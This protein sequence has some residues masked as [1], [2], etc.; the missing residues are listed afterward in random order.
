MDGPVSAET[1][2]A[3]DLVFH[4]AAN[5]DTDADGRRGARQ[6]RGHTEPPGVAASGVAGRQNRLHQ[7][8]GGPRPGCRS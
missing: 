1:P 5:I 4:L 8:G 7:L 6:R 3:V 2:P